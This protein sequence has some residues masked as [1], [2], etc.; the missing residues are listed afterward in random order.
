MCCGPLALLPPVL[1]RHCHRPFTAVSCRSLPSGPD[2]VP[3]QLAGLAAGAAGVGHL[4]W[5]ADSDG[6]LRRVPLLLSH[7]KAGVP[8]L[9]ML[10]VLRALYLSPADVRWNAQ[11][12]SLLWGACRWG[13]ML[14]QPCA[15]C[16]VLRCRVG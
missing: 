10:A 3:V 13:W 4:Q 7:D 8:S 11:A 1:P 15:R 2:A 14:R 9:A 6:V 16:L 5:A 12:H